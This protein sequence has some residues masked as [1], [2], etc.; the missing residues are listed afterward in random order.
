MS[1]EYTVYCDESGNDGPNYLNPAQPFYVLAGWIVPNHAIVDASVAIEMLRQTHCPTSNEVKFSNFRRRPWIVC[2]AMSRL[3]QIGLTPVYLVAEKRYCVAAKIVETLMDPMYN[4]RLAMAFTGDLLTKRELA[5]TLYE[6]LSGETLIS[7]AKA[8]RNP[9]A[10]GFEEILTR[11]T[12]E[13]KTTINPEL[14]YL[15]EGSRPNLAEIARVEV[16]A[17][18]S[19]G[20]E[21]GT[22]NLPCL[23]TFL[24]MIEELGRT[25][26]LQIRRIVHDEHGAYQDGY[27]K[28]FEQHKGAG[29]SDRIQIRGM[30]IPYG[31]VKMVNELDFQP[32]LSQPLV[33]AA[34]LL[35]GSIAHLSIS[36]VNGRR[37]RDQEVELGGL[38]LP[39]LILPEIMLGYALCAASMLARFGDA[40]T[41]AFPDA[42]K[43]EDKPDKIEWRSTLPN[44]N[45]L[46]V[47]PPPRIDSSDIAKAAVT[48]KFDLPL[49]GIA[50]DSEDILLLLLRLYPVIA[51]DGCASAPSVYVFSNGR[52]G[53][54]RFVAS[55]GWLVGR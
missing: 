23:I 54:S 2:E 39:T 17:V 43:G 14:S 11:I 21:M 42:V 36:L 28:A 1:D 8:Y 22:I 24:M 40:I 7:F 53:R 46:P 35:A 47:L 30:V 31:A 13:C 15:L 44:E 26:N 49:F 6:R 3:G 51:V 37:L 4:E 27:L 19:W 34:D 48:I 9:T 32:S 5:N 55:D 50:N 16:D 12:S 52:I 18:N 38:V 25:H 29:N 41:L 10:S 45:V 20:K 33:Q